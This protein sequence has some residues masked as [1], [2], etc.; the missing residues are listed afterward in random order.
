MKNKFNYDFFSAAV[1]IQAA[2][3]GHCARKPFQIAKQRTA[4]CFD[5]ILQEM[6]SICPDY[7]FI[8][9]IDVLIM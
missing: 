1:L 8:D 6:K 5:D 7:D 2:V 9:G 4:M 3:R